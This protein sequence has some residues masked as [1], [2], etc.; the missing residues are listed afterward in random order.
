MLALRVIGNQVRPYHISIPVQFLHDA[1]MPAPVKESIIY[2]TATEQRAIFEQVDG[3]SRIVFTA[4]LMDA[5]A[6][7]IDEVGGIAVA[8]C[9]QCIT[10]CGTCVV[11]K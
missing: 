6:T 3:Q 10:R 7:L 2:I 9:K 1:A 11:I 8:W 5:L 4:P